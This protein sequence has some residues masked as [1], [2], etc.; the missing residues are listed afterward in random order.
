MGTSFQNI[1]PA[2][3]GEVSSGSSNVDITAQV[4]LPSLPNFKKWDVRDG[5]SGR[6]YWTKDETCNTEAQLGNCIWNQLTGSAQLLVCDILNDSHTM[7]HTLHTF[8]STS[9]EDTMHSG[10]FDSTQACK[11]TSSFVKKIF[12]EIGYAKVCARDSINVDVPWSSGSGIIFDNICD[13]SVMIEF[14]HFP[15][16]D[17]PSIYS[18]MVNFVCY[19]VPST[20]MSEFF[21]S[22]STV[23]SFQC[24]DQRNLT[25]HEGI[26]KNLEYFKTY[27][28]KSIKKLKEKSGI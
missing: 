21:T 4:E 14:I 2:P 8:I 18:E 1:L 24:S 5:I 11:L 26:L 23:E 28:E 13:H 19:S 6:K 25:K 10:K 7:S 9:Y 27:A 12:T 3:Y 16:K 20:N 22:I 15:I 17:H